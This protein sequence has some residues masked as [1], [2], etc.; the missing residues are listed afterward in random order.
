MFMVIKFMGTKMKNSWFVRNS[1]MFIS[2]V[3][4]L[5]IIFGACLYMIPKEALN[6]KPPLNEMLLGLVAAI[7]TWFVL[8]PI[9][10][11]V[12]A[13][14]MR[15]I[16]GKDKALSFLFENENSESLNALDVRIR[17]LCMMVLK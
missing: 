5:G 15:M 13:A 16:Y 1:F 11:I 7:V 10:A 4:P 12:W 14:L 3:I 6:A 2:F 9:F 8:V 17:R